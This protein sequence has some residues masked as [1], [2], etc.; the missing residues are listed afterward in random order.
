MALKAKLF[1]NG[2]PRSSGTRLP[3]RRRMNA[4]VEAVCSCWIPISTN[5]SNRRSMEKPN[6]GRPTA[7][8]YHDYEYK[9]TEYFL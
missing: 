5:G 3:P 4:L 8:N 6:N 2:D 1:T 7:N 9:I